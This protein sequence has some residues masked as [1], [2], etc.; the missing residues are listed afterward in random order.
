MSYFQDIIMFISNMSTEIEQFIEQQG[1]NIS[2]GLI[3]NILYGCLLY[4]FYKVV[5]FAWLTV[6]RV[7]PMT[8]KELELLNGIHDDI[9]PQAIRITKSGTFVAGS[10]KFQHGSRQKYLSAVKRLYRKRAIESQGKVEG[11][12][13]VYEITPYGQRILLKAQNNSQ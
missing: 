4:C 9:L 7:F 3:T 13:A 6:N 1:L 12:K 8:A 11:M 10:C 2:T 5:Q